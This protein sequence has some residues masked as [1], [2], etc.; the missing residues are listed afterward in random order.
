MLVFLVLLFCL[1]NF[2]LSLAFQIV[3]FQFYFLASFALGVVSFYCR[4]K[5]QKSRLEQAS[6]LCGLRKDKPQSV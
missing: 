3:L 4:N 6:L 5:G 1:I 2:T